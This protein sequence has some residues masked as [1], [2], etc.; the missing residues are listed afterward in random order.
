[1]NS[2]LRF[3]MF[4]L[5]MYG[6][7]VF[8]AYNWATNP[9]DGSSGNPYQIS[10]AEQLE[11]IGSNAALLDDYFILVNDIDMSAYTFS[12]S[13]IA[14]DTDQD[15]IYT[16][17]NRFS[18][19][20]DGQGYRVSNLTII[21]SGT[22][23]N[24]GL[25]GLT[26]GSSWEVKN[27]GLEEINISVGNSSE[28]IGGLVSRAYGGTVSDCYV[29]GSVGSGTNTTKMGGLMGLS[30]TGISNCYVMCTITNG[31]GSSS[32]GGVVGQLATTY[33]QLEKCYST[34]IVNS[35]STINTI[36]AL[37][38]NLVSP[39]QVNDCYYLSGVGPNNG[40]GTPKYAYQLQLIETYTNWEFNSALLG[41]QGHW[42]MRSDVSYYPYLAWEFL[43]SD[44]YGDF[45][46]DMLDFAEVS[47][48]W[49]TVPGSLDFNW[50]CD[51]NNN[52]V[53]DLGDFRAFCDDWLIG[54]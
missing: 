17:E 12:N 15:N 34:S 29:T 18:G 16:D 46:I 40:I 14:P 54:Y 1:M 45:Q 9:G 39:A 49:K 19:S 33:G 37:V 48:S 23:Y 3:C 47:Q 50:L 2:K 4:I 25:I 32:T 20:L 52:Y 26:T 8:G 21:R 43:K 41:N 6:G 42:R 38:G 51:L 28:Y 30:S 53:I 44:F 35:G 10:T 22:S 7:A 31:T 5:C 27:L 36:G 24:I 11:S 13:P